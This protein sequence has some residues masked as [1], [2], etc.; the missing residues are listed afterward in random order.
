M[1]AMRKVCTSILL[2]VLALS[3]QLPAEVTATWIPNSTLYFQKG[4]APLNTNRLVA[5]LGTLTFTTTDNQLFDPNVLSL[6]VSVSFAFYGPLTWH[7]DGQGNPVYVDQETYF[8]LWAYSTV[9]GVTEARALNEMDG[10]SPLRTEKGNLS[11]QTFIAELYLVSDQ[12]WFRYK[13]NGLY[14]MTKGSLGAFRVGAAKNGSGYWDGNG[15]MVSVNGN[16][17][18]AVTNLL[19]SGSSTPSTPVPFGEPDVSPSYTLSIIDAHDFSVDKAYGAASIPIATAQLAITQGSSNKTYGVRVAFSSN[20]GF[21]LQ[22]GGVPNQYTIPYSLRFL[23][24]T[25][26][27]TSQIT[28]SNLPPGIHT[29]PIEVTGINSNKAEFAPAGYYSDTITIAI[30]PIDSI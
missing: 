16:D 26:V 22:L 23:N 25:V 2:L 17:P 20:N 15:M 19:P 28:W 12:E 10:S 21:A 27:P 30:T 11:V 3:F 14:V 13:P 6:G 29:K 4:F 1:A 8:S 7:N 9:K 24:Q 18:L 5:H